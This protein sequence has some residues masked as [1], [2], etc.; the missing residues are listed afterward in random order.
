VRRAGPGH[1]VVDRAELGIAG[2]W[3][4]T[5]QLRVSDFEAHRATVEVP[6]E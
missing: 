4:V 6:V 3:A 1:Y 2:D 5:V